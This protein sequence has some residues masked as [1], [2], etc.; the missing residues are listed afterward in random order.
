MAVFVQARP[1]VPS[2]S[3]DCSTVQP[4]GSV[5]VAVSTFVVRNST[6]AS[7]GATVVGTWTVWLD[8]LPAV[9]AAPAND[10]CPSTADAFVV[11][12]TIAPTATTTPAAPMAIPRRRRLIALTPPERS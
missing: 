4:A 9:L 6:S 11:V 1:R 12:T 10:S 8:R 2:P 5:T 7:P 3:R